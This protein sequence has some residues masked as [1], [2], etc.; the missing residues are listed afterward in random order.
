MTRLVVGNNTSVARPPM[1]C[2]NRVGPACVNTGAST[3][4]LEDGLMTE[5]YQA[6][7]GTPL[8]RGVPLFARPYM[9]SWYERQQ[10]FVTVNPPWWRFWVK[11]ET[12]TRTQWVRESRSIGQDLA[13]YLMQCSGGPRRAEELIVGMSKN[14]IDGIWG[15]QLEC[16]TGV[17]STSYVATTANQSYAAALASR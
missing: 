8:R 7:D 1:P 9:L 14:S 5:Y 12:F 4:P 3:N 17:V 13:D 10:Y 2:S 16:T 6:P 15:V 11:P